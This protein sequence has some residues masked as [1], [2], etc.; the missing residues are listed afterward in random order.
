MKM[1]LDQAIESAQL[2]RGVV[3]EHGEVFWRKG[4]HFVVY[5]RNRGEFVRSGC[6]TI[7]AEK[8]PERGIRGW[9]KERAEVLSE[10]YQH[11]KDLVNI[12]G[13]YGLWTA[14]QYGGRAVMGSLR[15]MQLAF[16]MSVSSPDYERADFSQ[17]N[18]VV[19]V[20]KPR[21]PGMS[22][23]TFLDLGTF[24]HGLRDGLFGDAKNLIYNYN[25]CLGKGHDTD[26]YNM[27][28]LLK[29]LDPKPPKDG[30]PGDSSHF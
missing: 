6:I 28:E 19:K 25:N 16:A 9:I 20:D 5:D 7:P 17:P 10:H 21:L 3:E 12:A 22:E 4:D 18:P 26:R 8:K 13:K 1:N 27:S 15:A 24:D 23:E 14:A 30:E 29:R 11:W 2:Q